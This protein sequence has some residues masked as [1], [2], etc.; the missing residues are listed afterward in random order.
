MNLTQQRTFSLPSAPN[1]AGHLEEGGEGA[2]SVNLALFGA[3]EPMAGVTG[4][5][6]QAV[7]D[8]RLQRPSALL[9][10]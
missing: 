9:L 2:R 3:C 7:P 1:G 8:F 4:V 5:P 6:M 10:L